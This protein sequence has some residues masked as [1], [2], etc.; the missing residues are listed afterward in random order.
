MGSSIKPV[1]KKKNPNGKVK[2][3][4]TFLCGMR[5]LYQMFRALLPIVLRTG[6]R[7]GKHVST[8]TLSVHR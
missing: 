8:P 4:A 7:S 3:T 5:A 6:H 1:E 2:V